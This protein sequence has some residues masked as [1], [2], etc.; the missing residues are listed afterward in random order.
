MSQ[1]SALTSSI[2]IL[3]SEV[4]KTKPG[5]ILNKEVMGEDIAFADD[6][7][8][9]GDEHYEDVPLSDEESGDKTDQTSNQA[10]DTKKNAISWVH[11]K[12]ISTNR[13]K[14]R[15][16]DPNVRNPLFAGAELVD[17][18]E[19]A[20]LKS[21]YHP[22]TALFAEK[23]LNDES[24]DY[25][26][27]PM[28]DFSLK[29]F[30][31]RF[32]FRNPKKV[33]KKANS[34]STRVFGRLPSADKT[35]NQLTISSKEYVNQPENRIPIDEKFIHHYLKQR[36]SQK[37]DGYDSD[38]ESVTSVEFESLLDR[39]E[40]MAKKDFAKDLYKDDKNK[41]TKKS[42]KSDEDSDEESDD[43]LGEQFDDEDLDGED[44]DMEFDEDDPEFNDAFGGVD[45]E[46][47]EALEENDPELGP[48]KRKRGFD[49]ITS[50]LFA[51][52]DEFAQLLEA[53]ESDSGLSDAEVEVDQ[54]TE[55]RN[56]RKLGRN[57][58]KKFNRKDID[59]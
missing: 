15:R 45:S 22:S 17:L 57:K 12:N 40:P 46:L 42:K 37:T 43:E 9:D 28:N 34:T 2:L 1:S 10:K 53:N 32:V 8:D 55:F 20:L 3:L 35:S 39:L 6:V 23:I 58:K 26:G 25:S 5:L 16:Y 7:D 21:H 24:I 48:K 4:I 44:S 30:L 50:D 52:A 56:R 11:N 33:D 36:I 27:D 47:E 51:S 41:K 18:W 31:D 14:T 29:H 38:V 19:L 49:K 59:L 13:T 54:K